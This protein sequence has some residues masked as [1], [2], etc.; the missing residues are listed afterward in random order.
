MTFLSSFSR[1][2]V[3][4]LPIRS[5]KCKKQGFQIAFP[6]NERKGLFDLR[7]STNFGVSPVTVGFIVKVKDPRDTVWFESGDG[8]R[9]EAPFQ[10]GHYRIFNHTYYGKGE[11][12][13]C[14][15]ALTKRDQFWQTKMF[16]VYVSEPTRERGCLITNF[17]QSIA[18]GQVGK[19]SSG[20]D[21]AVSIANG[22]AAKKIVWR[23]EHDKKPHEGTKLVAH[24][25][26]KQPGKWRGNVTAYDFEEKKDSRYFSVIMAPMK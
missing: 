24:H 21:V 8:T 13:G 17:M 11:Y 1:R 26:Y 5:R 23:F 6:Q 10:K 15:T 7:L 22:R 25:V 9:I 4:K 18:A 16:K 2:P 19:G 3:K 20:L 14:F 12:W